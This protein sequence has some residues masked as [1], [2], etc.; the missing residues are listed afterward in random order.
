[1]HKNNERIA[2][3]IIDDCV[4]KVHYGVNKVVI[5]LPSYRK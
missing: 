1:M 2:T 5:L 3:F 4:N